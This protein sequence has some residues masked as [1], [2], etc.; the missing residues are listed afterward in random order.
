MQDSGSMDGTSIRSTRLTAWVAVAFSVAV[1]VVVVIVCAH[2]DV[3]RCADGWSSL[4][5]TFRHH[6]IVIAVAA[7]LAIGVSIRSV[8]QHP[9]SGRGR[10][11]IASIII[12]VAAG[13]GALSMWIILHLR[14]ELRCLD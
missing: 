2:A 11:D 9:P 6:V 12:I 13:I 8:Y 4:G 5:G 3:V 1:D 10:V 7:L 14:P